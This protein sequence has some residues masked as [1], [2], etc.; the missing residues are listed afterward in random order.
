M[1]AA[2]ILSFIFCSGVV[3]LAQASPAGGKQ[4]QLLSISG[5]V[6]RAD[7]RAPL[8]RVEISLNGGGMTGGDGTDFV[9]RSGGEDASDAAPKPG[10]ITDEKGHFTIANLKSGTYMLR[11][12]RTGM[13]QK[14]GGEFGTIVRLQAP[15]SQNVTIL[16]L[17]SGA[18]FRT[19]PE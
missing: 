7:T 2:R 13:V 5:T 15:D 8:P 14:N 18:T 19:R 9:F 3:L 12:S 6:L 11:A 16:M 4:P 1:Q 10:V 17:V